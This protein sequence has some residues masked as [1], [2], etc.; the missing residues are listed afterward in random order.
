MKV[1]LTNMAQVILWLASL[2]GLTVTDGNEQWC[3]ACRMGGAGTLEG[4]GNGERMWPWQVARAVAGRPVGV[5]QR[6]DAS[7]SLKTC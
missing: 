2:L 4:V 7:C 6:F 3:D 1:D 5:L